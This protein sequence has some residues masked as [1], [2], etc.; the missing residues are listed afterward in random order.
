MKKIIK[1]INLLLVALFLGGTLNAQEN[2]SYDQDFAFWWDQHEEIETTDTYYRWRVISDQTGANLEWYGYTEDLNNPHHMYAKFK[3]G[4]FNKSFNYVVF[5]PNKNDSLS[6][7]IDHPTTKGLSKLVIGSNGKDVEVFVN[8]ETQGVFAGNNSTSPI[9]VDLIDAEGAYDLAIK[10]GPNGN[11]RVFWLKAYGWTPATASNAVTSED[12][13]S[14]EMSV[15][16]PLAAKDTTMYGGHGFGLDVNNADEDVEIEKVTTSSDGSK[17]IVHFTKPTYRHNEILISYDRAQGQLMSS[18]GNSLASFEDVLVTNNSPILPPLVLRPVETNTLGDTVFITFDKAIKQYNFD[19]GSGFSINGSVSGSIAI[20]SLYTNTDNTDQLVLL[21]ATAAS[22]D[23]VLTLSYSGE[24]IMSTD[25]GVLEAFTDFALVNKMTGAKAELSIMPATDLLGEY[26]S[27][28]FSKQLNALPAGEEAS[29][30][31][32]VNG[33]ER[34]VT[35]VT[36][37]ASDARIVNVYLVTATV[38]TDNITV[39]YTGGTHTTTEGAAIRLFTDETVVNNSPGIPPV[40]T[41]AVTDSISS[42]AIIDFKFNLR[43]LSV[44]GIVKGDFVVDIVSTD[45]TVVKDS[46]VNFRV[47]VMIDELT[48][49]PRFIAT[50]LEAE[51]TKPVQ[52]TD[53]LYLTYTGTALQGWDRGVVLPFDRILH[54]QM[55]GADAH[56]TESALAEDLSSILVEFT[57]DLDV[58]YVFDDHVSTSAE[59]QQVNIDPADFMV[60]I[61][62]SENIANPDIL[63]T[64]RT[65]AT[66]VSRYFNDENSLIVNLDLDFYKIN[67]WDTLTTQTDRGFVEWMFEDSTMTSSVTTYENEEGGYNWDR[68]ENVTGTW[69]PQWDELLEARTDSGLVK[70]SYNGVE[71]ADTLGRFVPE[72]DTLVAIPF[73]MDGVEFSLDTIVVKDTS[74]VEFNLGDTI[75]GNFQSYMREG[76]ITWNY[77]DTTIVSLNRNAPYGTL[78]TEYPINGTYT[79]ILDTAYMPTDSTQVFWK[80]GDNIKL[81]YTP[82]TNKIKTVEKPYD[83]WLTIPDSMAIVN[84]APVYDPVTYLISSP[85]EFAGSY[86]KD[87]V[88]TVDDAYWLLTMDYR[89]KEIGMRSGIVQPFTFD[90]TIPVDAVNK[91]AETKDFVSR[92]SDEE[93]LTVYPLVSPVKSTLGINNADGFTHIQI[94]SITGAL[95]VNK[96]I[97]DSYLDIPV[98]HMSNGM[99]IVVLFGSDTKERFTGKIVKQ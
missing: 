71:M 51:F 55:A 28:V 31:V 42:K 49:L 30:V 75:V 96:P 90:F 52:F 13:M 39:S 92:P 89:Y 68:V 40:S 34:A 27:L 77:G 12:G 36:L 73:Y 83:E 21:L 20:D 15:S 23:D 78:I 5:I 47:P 7:T 98:A 3:K 79:A 54:S 26:V 9:V 16:E 38:K 44:G 22:V 50:K 58:N 37:D 17:I 67:D 24:V 93:E 64:K 48:G 14:M 59:A 32:K 8:G 33:A 1:L 29:F 41:L 84:Q 10:S 56:A 46:L 82:G 69:V 6:T 94:Y 2:Q 97:S 74:Y 91:L 65:F 70:W 86:F 35:A 99:Y 4:V 11:P 87:S 53:S 60:S 85:A 19:N 57:Q 43:V 25:E 72:N 95:M 45:G 81:T 76:N 63:P 62:D 88:R 66:F 61:N 18:A 80:G